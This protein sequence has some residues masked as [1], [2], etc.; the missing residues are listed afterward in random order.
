MVFAAQP[1]LIATA[2]NRTAHVLDWGSRSLV[3]FGAGSFVA[4]YSPA[5]P[6]S[7]GTFATLHGHS[8]RV[9]CV[10]FAP[11]AACPV[12]VSGS[13]DS[14][15]RVWTPTPGDLSGTASSW[16]CA[17]VLKGH[18]GAVV[19]VA[20]VQLP[21]Q[22]TLLSATAATDGAIRIFEYSTS[23][24][25]QG[26]D[27]CVEPVQ[28]IDIGARTALDVALAMLP[29]PGG[30]G[31]GDYVLLLGTGDTDSKV[32]LYT[33]GSV[34]GAQFSG[35]LA[36]TGHEDWV[37]S[38]S[39][40]RI[41]ADDCDAS[42]ATIAHWGAGDTI[43]ASGS[44]D[45]YVRLWRIQAAG[46]C[47]NADGSAP[48]QAGGDRHAAQA[49]LDAFASGLDA[50]ASVADITSTV[51]GGS[52]LATDSSQ[53]LSTHAH[54]VTADIGGGRRCAYTVAL[55]SVLLGHDGWVHSVSWGR[56]AG[57][58]A[59]LSASGDSSAML[60][61][62]DSDAGVWASVSRLGETG[63][64]VQGFMGAALSPD[65]TA[66]L[67]HGY[68]GSFHMWRQPPGASLDG[69]VWEPR[70]SL[71]GHFGAVQDVCW[72]QLGSYL[73]SSSSDQS[74]RLFAPWI[75]DAG[76]SR[77]WHELARPQ[78][79]GY[80]MRCAAFISPVQY[81]SGA[82]E[83]V[84]RVFRATQQF[85]AAWRALTN[86][87]GADVGK[88]HHLA[89]GASLPTLGLSNKAIEQGQVQALAGGDQADDTHD[90]NYEVRRTHTDVAASAVAR[91]QQEGESK[92]QL[93]EPPL[94]ERLLRHTL[95]PEEDKLYGHPYEI[96]SLAAAHGGDLIATACR[97]T[98]ARHAGIRLYSTQTWQPP[99]VQAA[100]GTTQAAEPLAAHALTITRLC[101]GPPPAT[102]AGDR[103]L[104]SASRDRS[105]A[106]YQRTDPAGKD[107]SGQPIY[108][109]ATGP[110][111]LV[112][113][114]QKAHARIIW[115]AAWSPD[116]CF[117][118]TA[119]RD[120][121]VRLWETA[122]A[123]A[124]TAK[125]V[126]LAFPESVTA[127]DL[128]PV[129]LTAPDEAAAGVQ[130]VL[131]AALESGRVFVL[132]SAAAD[133]S[134]VPTAWQPAE[135]PRHDTHTAMVHRLAWRPRPSCGQTTSQRSWQLA[136]ASDDQTV[137]ITTVNI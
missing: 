19:A 48:A 69:S 103:Y 118:A 9:N 85:V 93:A 88:G 113:R 12:V 131:A 71:T 49:M 122:A 3:A 43:L 94:E 104:L 25:E 126:T 78:I 6:D 60:W 35:A 115:D 18:Q 77:G 97:A 23:A 38:L 59:L 119:S 54:A 32:H 112:H 136:S 123:T 121:T 98:S 47:D 24:L 62:P 33:R 107:A 80:G 7:R 105:W 106:I 44:Q 73:L 128:L 95:W 8:Q 70:P 30:R 14:T 39:F 114:Q 129:L 22:Q 26:Q 116:S 61:V 1:E 68:Q 53:Q 36:L 27:V 10:R 4:L 84:V 124:G 89:M 13:A 42:N 117:F 15:A 74:T 20:T 2:C 111:T 81:V 16:K 132:V 87:T 120:K 41:A 45:K 57:A 67:A 63:G 50:G 137:R 56:I 90:D 91:A 21:G 58:P 52:S 109:Q 55:D 65:G 92:S 72:D 108:A 40:V 130:Y 64:A 79:H 102:V 135:I 66:L 110:Y 82:D 34:S 99:A 76:H 96:F 29:V 133:G 11:G 134:S 28:V 51:V 31:D 37:T 46:H 101:F 86:S 127:I 75:D 83:K 17:A 125:P 5:D 100:E